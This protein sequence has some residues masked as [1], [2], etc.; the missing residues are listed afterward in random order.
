MLPIH[1]YSQNY[2]GRSGNWQK[3]EILYVMPFLEF[4]SKMIVLSLLSLRVII[5]MLRIPLKCLSIDKSRAIAKYKFFWLFFRAL[6]GNFSKCGY[7]CTSIESAKFQNSRNT[8]FMKFEWRNRK[9]ASSCNF[10]GQND[11]FQYQKSITV[12]WHIKLKHKVHRTFCI[13]HRQFYSWKLFF[14]KISPMTSW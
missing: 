14:S 9:L 13:T 2:I 3:V 11:R 6:L 10:S 1:F 12:M 8:F 5:S 4:W 7:W